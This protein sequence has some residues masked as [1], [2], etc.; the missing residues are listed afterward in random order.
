MWSIFAKVTNISV[1]HVCVVQVSMSLCVCM[2]GGRV[3]KGV[4]VCGCFYRNSESVHV[5]VCVCVCT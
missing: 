2:L 4:T 5:C 1:Y 3:H